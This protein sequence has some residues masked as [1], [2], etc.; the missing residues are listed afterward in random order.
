MNSPNDPGLRSWVETA[1]GS[2]FPIQNLPWGIFSDPSNPAPRA[3]I[4]IGDR[5]LDVAV[6]QEAGLL[7]P[8]LPAGIFRS[9]ALNG[10]MALG[11]AVWRGTRARVSFLLSSETAALR[12]DPALSAKALFDASR[13]TQHLPIEVQGFTDFYSSR[14]HAT[15]VGKMFR[16]KANPL[17]PNWLYIPV[18]Y[19]GRASTVAVSGTP[20]RRPLGQIKPPGAEAPVFGPSAK[21]DF[22]LEMGVIVGQ[23]NPMGETLSVAKAEEAIFGFALLN[24]WSARDIQRWEYA[25]LGPF[26]AKA[27]A[28]ALGPWIVTAEALEPFRAQGPI[29]EPAP[30]PYLAQKG[31]KNYDI[32]L[33]VSLRP[34]G[35]THAATISRTN[36]AR[37]YWSS[38]QQ[39]AHHTACGCAMRV[40]DLLGSGTISGPSADSFGSLLELTWNGQ[41]PLTLPGGS[42]RSFLEDGDVVSFTG[43]AQRNGISIGFGLCEGEILP[44]RPVESG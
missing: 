10:F 6:L 39:L 12:D 11:P 5:V 31:A 32:E 16:D 4:R 1:Q 13:V 30:L 23:A 15:N 41:K 37:M 34:K 17:L 7:Q 3:G 28:T 33:E 8:E 26:Q 22:E 21:L 14:E 35:S 24:D 2:D 27:F 19:N 44:A 25:P 43:R 42:I 29:Q 40:G 36:F 20:V 18:A 38:A 9:G